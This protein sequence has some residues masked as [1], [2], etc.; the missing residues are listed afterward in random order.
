[1]KIKCIWEYGTY[2]TEGRTYEVIREKEDVYLITDDNGNSNWFYKN[3][4]KILEDEIK[5]E[6]IVNSPIKGIKLNFLCKDY[7]DEEVIRKD[8]DNTIYIREDNGDA[9]TK[10]KPSEIPKLIEWLQK[11]NTYIEQNKTKTKEMTIE[12]IEKALGHRIRIVGGEK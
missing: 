12:E 8:I 10:L 6:D 1:M 11:V 4:F 9:V 5:F 2:I 3:K 7:F